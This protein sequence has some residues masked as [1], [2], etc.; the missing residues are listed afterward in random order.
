MH[1]TLALGL[2]AAL[3]LPATLALSAPRPLRNGDRLRNELNDGEVAT[4]WVYED[5]PTA[6]AVAKQTKKPLAVVFR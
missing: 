1:R 4:A 2:A 6:M 3:A 5:L